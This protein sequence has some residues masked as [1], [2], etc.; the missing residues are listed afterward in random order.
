M[1]ARRRLARLLPPLALGALLAAGPAFAQTADEIDAV[2]VW[3]NQQGYDAGPADGM[4]G[5]RTRDAISQWE[6]EHG[7]PATGEVSGWLVEMALGGPEAAAQGAEPGNDASGLI[8][9]DPSAEDAV[10]A[11]QGDITAFSGTGA[12]QFSE[13][14]DGA[15]VITDGFPWRPGIPV[16]PR[17]IAIVDTTYGI[18]TAAPDSSVPVPLDNN[19]VEVPGSAFVPLFLAFDRQAAATSSLADASGIVWRFD[20][21]AL[22]FE[23][24]GYVLTAAEPG[25]TIAFSDDGVVLTGFVLAPL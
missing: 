11:L 13:R 16:A 5:A 24:E 25:A 17:T 12:L 14:E 15:I 7:Q 23:L 3:L 9:V 21:G 19:I 8:S 10:S 2:Q 6:S 20:Q 4:M 18:F 22:R 1:T